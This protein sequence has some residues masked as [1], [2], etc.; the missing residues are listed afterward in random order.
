M[1]SNAYVLDTDVF[2]EAARRY[3]A[4]DLGSKFWDIL[5]KHADNGVVESIDWVK[6]ELLEGKDELARWADDSFSNAFFST[7]EEDV[8]ESYRKIITWVQNQ[9]QYREAAKADFADGADGWLI[10]YAMTRGR[11]IVTHENPDP[12]I[13]RKVPIPNVCE[14]FNIRYIDTFAML[15]EL[16]AK[17]A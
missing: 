14:Q 7:I 8:Q 11:I 15:R 4:F 17:L 2:I 3:Y 1:Q 13:R 5:L 9:P 6:N 16:G 12:N 10:A